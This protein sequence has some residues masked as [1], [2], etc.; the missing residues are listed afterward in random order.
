[1]IVDD[2]MIVGKKQNHNVHDLVLTAWLETTR[3]VNVKL[4]YEKL[5]HKKQ[6]VDF[7]GETYTTSGCKPA[8]SKV[9]AITA[10]P[11]PI[12]KKQVQSFICMINYLSKFSM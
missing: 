1:M 3:K 7:F 5:Q 6:E 10:T 8:Q 2:I 11:A 9:S 12:C 4:N